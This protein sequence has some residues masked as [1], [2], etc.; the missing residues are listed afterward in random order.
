MSTVTYIQAVL[1]LIFV[2][3][4]M[5]GTSW[6]VRRLGLA[7]PMATPIGRRRRL[8]MVEVLPVDARR[9][10]VLVRRD[11]V[12]HLLLVGPTDS[13]VVERGIGAEE[14]SL[15]PPEPAPE[16]STSEDAKP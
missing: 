5:F 16:E 8:Q 4:L 9:R 13:L 15:L 7:G 2:V 12:E 3:G 10:L 14:F 11:D 6:L 1:A